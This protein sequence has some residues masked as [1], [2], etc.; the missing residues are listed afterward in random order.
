MQFTVAIDGPAAA[1]KG[2]ISR[3]V[4]DRF[5]LAHLDTGALYRAV[6][7]KAAATGSDPVAAALSLT[8]E[9]LA[10]AD[11]RT[12]EAGQAASKVAVIPEVRQALLDYQR[13]F[14]RR[15]GGA[16]LDGRDIGTVI[17]PEAEVKLFVTAS[18]EVRA[19]RRWLEVGGDAAQ[20][21]AEVRARDERDMTRADAP[22][23]P[24]ANAVQIDTSTMSIEEA[25]AAA[26]AEVAARLPG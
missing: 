25:V 20:V 21:L 22:L 4:A 9:D 3:A 12:L 10:R 17:C 5:G 6:G 16:V 26:C 13:D 1:G 23:K 7:V 11:L 24:A 2:T 14:A 18:A 8:P 15:A 19:H